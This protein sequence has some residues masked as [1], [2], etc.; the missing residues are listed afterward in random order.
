M[1]LSCKVERYHQQFF[2]ELLVATGFSRHPNRTRPLRPA[3]MEE[4]DRQVEVLHEPDEGKALQPTQSFEKAV[5]KEYT[6]Y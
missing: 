2:V 6:F 4:A 5:I 3:G 1:P